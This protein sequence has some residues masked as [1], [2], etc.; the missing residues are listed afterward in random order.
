VVS[1][2]TGGGRF[3]GFQWSGE[4]TGTKIKR[5]EGGGAKGKT[6]C[7]RHHEW[8]EADDVKFVGTIV[9]WVS[10]SRN[11]RLCGYAMLDV[12]HQKMRA[13]N[14]LPFAEGRD[15]EVFQEIS[16]LSRGIRNSAFLGRCEDD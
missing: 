11:M 1:D 10:S 14:T 8:F 4:V 9:G 13:S 7:C 15:A 16:L 2:L 5:T 12:H 6:P 3:E